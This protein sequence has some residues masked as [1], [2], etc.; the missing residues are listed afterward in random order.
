M[1]RV[2]SFRYCLY[3]E[4]VKCVS[5]TDILLDPIRALRLLLLYAN[6]ITIARHHIY[7]YHTGESRE[8]NGF[9]S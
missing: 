8:Q 1:A 6:Y 2:T 5:N 9:C 3:G 4:L 7:S